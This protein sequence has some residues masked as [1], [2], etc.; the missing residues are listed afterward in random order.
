V[1][2]GEMVGL[3]GPNGAGKSTLLQLAS[4]VLRPQAGRVWLNERDIHTLAHQEVA[5]HVAMVPQEFSVPFAYTVRQLVELGR[6][7][8]LGLL[9][10]PRREDAQAVDEALDAT[11]LSALSQR[12]FNHLSG[13][14]R[15]RVLVALALAQSGGLLLL[16]EP[17]AHLDVRHQ[18]EIME[19]LCRLNQE[20]HLTIVAALHDL[21]LA[22]RYFPRLILLHH[23]IVADGSPTAV[24]DAHLLSR[25]Y[26][27]AIKVG[28]LRGE[29][30]L[31]VLPSSHAAADVGPLDDCDAL[32][33]VHLVAG[34]GS[35]ELAMRALADAG[36][37]FSV[38]ALNIGDSD[39]QLA[40]HLAACWVTEPPF[41]PVSA[42]GLAA[43]RASMLEA[44][45]VIICPVPF[46]AG[47]LPLL[48]AAVEA[49][50][51]GRRVVLW[52]P[53]AESARAADP[54][55]MLAR[56]GARDFS[57]GRATA[58]YTALLAAGAHVVTAA[59]ALADIV[60]PLPDP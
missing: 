44:E 5:R 31:S 39:H 54:K 57:D 43:A 6:T 22:A 21:N 13:G 51:N 55:V 15:Q 33:K 3:L 27:A 46:G 28:I 60:L 4:G 47:N 10:V 42:S 32:P 41:A 52:E 20:R 9:G 12:V 2:A 50:A 49:A 11:A 35:G 37:P 29:V 30:S 18:V 17:T 23:E 45:V 7:P 59:A 40:T 1:R 58:L 56:V 8:H 38:A 53:G 14:E 19:L 16:D 24:L 25:A 36:V 34:G 26:E 48:Q